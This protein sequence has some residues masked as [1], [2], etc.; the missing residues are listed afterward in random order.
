[1]GA[2]IKSTGSLL[3]LYKAEAVSSNLGLAI[4]YGRSRLDLPAQGIGAQ[5]CPLDPK[6]TAVMRQAEHNDHTIT[7]VDPRTHGPNSS[8]LSRAP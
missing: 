4:A 3:K 2:Y 5:P 6:S 7:T 1:M 8:G